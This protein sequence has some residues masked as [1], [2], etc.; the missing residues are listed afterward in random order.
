[1]NK[2]EEQIKEMNQE[3]EDYRQLVVYDREQKKQQ[4]KENVKD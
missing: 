4:E 3:E 2:Q 1:M